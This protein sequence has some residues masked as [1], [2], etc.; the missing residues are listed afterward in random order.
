M[1]PDLFRAPPLAMLISF[2][3]LAPSRT[4]IAPCALPREA[5]GAKCLNPR[6]LP[7]PFP[8]VLSDGGEGDYPH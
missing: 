5:G 2:I 8:A 7:E 4:E 1:G 3:G 6:D